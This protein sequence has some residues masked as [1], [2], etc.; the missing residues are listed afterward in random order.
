MMHPGRL[1]GHIRKKLRCVKVGL[2]FPK[3][4]MIGNS[5]KEAGF[6]CT[7]LAYME[8]KT[9]QYG[10]RTYDMVNKKW[11]TVRPAVVR[12]CGVYGN[13]MRRAQESGATDEDYF[14]MALMDYQAEA[15][16]TFKYHH[17]WEIL[18][19]SLKWMDKARD[20]AK[21]KGSRA[22]GSS[23]ANDEAL[24]R[25]MVTEMASQEKEERLVVLEI[26]RREVE[27]GE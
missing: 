3:N 20:V 7:V 16:T 6:W 9:K 17:C 10:R 5:G 19:N 23:S 2:T 1:R 18:K 11:K 25:L 21:K 13:V 14:E 4:S 15:G 26:K 24:A 12:L 8:S 27:C 22:S